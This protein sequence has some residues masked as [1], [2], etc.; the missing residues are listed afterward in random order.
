[1]KEK[2]RV[3]EIVYAKY[4]FSEEELKTISNNIA[5][6]IN[7]KARLIDSKKSIMSKF[8]AE[9][10]DKEATI[11]IYANNLKDKYE[12]RDIKCYMEFDLKEK[13]RKYYDINTEE[14]VKEEEMRHDDFQKDLGI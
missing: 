5:Q 2:I 10:D 13:K 3:E 9:I 6:T 11:N 4:N 14:L 7:E 8:K 1:M 12:Y